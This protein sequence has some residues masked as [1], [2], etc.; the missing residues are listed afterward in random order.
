MKKGLI[1]LFV[2]IVLAANSA[3]GAKPANSVPCPFSSTWAGDC[4]FKTGTETMM[5]NSNV[6]V[7]LGDYTYIEVNAPDG[8]ILSA[9]VVRG[10]VWIMGEGTNTLKLLRQDTTVATVNVTVESAEYPVE[11]EFTGYGKP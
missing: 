10:N 5:A 1:L 3:C 11:V 7:G 8:A 2:I 9:S 6:P 4:L